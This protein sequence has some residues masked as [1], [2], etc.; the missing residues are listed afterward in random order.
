MYLNGFEKASYLA[1]A[2]AGRREHTLNA[3]PK[4]YYTGAL[5]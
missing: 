4:V 2:E 3:N 1:M 5:L